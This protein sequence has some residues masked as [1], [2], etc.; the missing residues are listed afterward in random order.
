[1]AARQPDMTEPR[2]KDIDTRDQFEQK[3]NAFAAKK[4]KEK[5]PNPM[6]SPL[7]EMMNVPDQEEKKK[8]EG[9]ELNDFIEII[10]KIGK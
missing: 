1:M 10:I 3:A 8:H 5:E 7:S 2:N 4:A 9:E 6:I